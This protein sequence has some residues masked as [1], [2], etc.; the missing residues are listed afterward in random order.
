MKIIVSYLFTYRAQSAAEA[1][2][3]EHNNRL[4]PPLDTAIWWVE[5]VAR[6][7]G[8][9][10][11]RANAHRMQ[12]HAYHSVDAILSIIISVVLLCAFL[13]HVISAIFCGGR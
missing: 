7:G 2:S 11:G 12:W 3:Y 9:K 1:V 8:Y 4:V 10:L 13:K 5:H 6:T